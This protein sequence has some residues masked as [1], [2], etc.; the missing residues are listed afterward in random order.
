M[1][2]FKSLED[3]I[4]KDKNKEASNE[5]DV[6]LSSSVNSESNFELLSKLKPIDENDNEECNNII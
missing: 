2:L 3:E 4:N 5:S 6:S 1:R